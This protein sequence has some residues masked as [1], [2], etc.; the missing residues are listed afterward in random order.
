MLEV[1]LGTRLITKSGSFGLRNLIVV[2]MAR[3]KARGTG[4]VGKFLYLPPPVL[5]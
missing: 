1:I 4:L 5:K 3:S 2:S